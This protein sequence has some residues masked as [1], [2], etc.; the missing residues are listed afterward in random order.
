[1]FLI[2]YIEMD[3]DIFDIL[4]LDRGVDPLPP[5]MPADFQ[6]DSRVALELLPI[7]HCFE[8][9]CGCNDLRMKE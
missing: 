9:A 6:L 5:R 4:R 1:M 7:L 2:E 3:E 8:N